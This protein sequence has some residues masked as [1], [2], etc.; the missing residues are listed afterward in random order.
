[1]QVPRLKSLFSQGK[2]IYQN[3]GSVSLLKRG[4]AFASSL[5]FEYQTY[6]LYMEPLEGLRLPNEVDVRPEVEGLTF[7]IVTTNREA[8]ELEAD[9]FEFRSQV[10]NAR[11]KLD[12]GATAFC[13]F[14]GRELAHIGW[15]ALSQEAMDS[16]GAPPYKVDFSDHEAYDGGIWT[17]PK[18]RRMG[19]HVYETLKRLEFAQHKGTRTRRYVIASDNVA[20]QKGRILRGTLPLPG[21][22][23]E[24]RL[25]RILWW[26]SWREKPL[27]PGSDREQCNAGA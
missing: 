11:E 26:K 6:Y 7:R 27:P 15:V 14:V 17:K 3:E 16:L 10:V 20:I 22:H 4:L 25:L 1:M 5:I 12:K 24:G 18:Y 2:H 9:G 8:D 23:A 21:P 13:I 19:I